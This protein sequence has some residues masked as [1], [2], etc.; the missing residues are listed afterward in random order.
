MAPPL[1]LQ[2]CVDKGGYRSAQSYIVAFASFEN[3]P[4][5]S[6]TTIKDRQTHNSTIN[7]A[8][9]NSARREKM[10]PLRMGRICQI[11]DEFYFRITLAHISIVL[12]VAE[13]NTY[14]APLTHWLQL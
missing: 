7:N 8:D 13:S 3:D 1:L 12:L 6:I 4:N 9:L 11:G 2:A 5:P 14:L 10:P